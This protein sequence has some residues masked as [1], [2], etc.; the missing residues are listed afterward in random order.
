MNSVTVDVKDLPGQLATLAALAASGTEVKV[1]DGTTTVTLVAPPPDKPR[2]P[3]IFNMH[4]GGYMSPDFN[5]E[6]DD[7][8]FLRG[9]I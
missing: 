8:A 2:R 5:D 9:D 3:F 4:P 1:T 6:I 7:E